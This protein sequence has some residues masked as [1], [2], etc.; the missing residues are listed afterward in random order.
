MK[1]ELKPYTFYVLGTNPFRQKNV[2]S[3]SPREKVWSWAS[4]RKTT[5]QTNSWGLTDEAI[6]SSE[7]DTTYS[8]TKNSLHKK[9]KN[10][11]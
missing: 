5:T 2:L 11:P 1:K 3:I 4:D 8:I 9:M 10:K 7:P 6:S